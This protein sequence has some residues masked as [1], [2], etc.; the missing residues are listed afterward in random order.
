M[1]LY[2]GHRNAAEQERQRNANKPGRVWF[3]SAPARSVLDF[4]RVRERGTLTPR[5]GPRSKGTPL[6]PKMERKMERN[7]FDA[8][9]GRDDAER[10]A[11][12]LVSKRY[13]L[14]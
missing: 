10:K 2:G 8:G 14:H 1:G 11:W 7:G 6:E 3:P 5:A 4:Y 9:L 13:R 12:A